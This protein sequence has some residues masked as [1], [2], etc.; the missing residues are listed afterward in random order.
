MKGIINS[1]RVAVIAVLLAV[2]AFVSAGICLGQSLPDCGGDAINEVT[3]RI[4]C[5]VGDAACWLSKGG[6][7]TDYI[8]IKTPR[9]QSGKPP[10]WEKIS[11]GS[12]EKGDVAVFLSLSHYAYVE[13]VTRDG[14]GRP[15][16]LDL[17]EYNYGGCWVDRSNMVTDKY[18]TVNKRYG[19]D[20]N[21]VDGGFLRP[22]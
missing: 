11:A 18:K 19:V 9:P 20:P 15:I 10:R 16:S 5:T 12:V 7:C 2:F 22:M 17:S 4:G 21:I 13:S 6:Y 3:K 1:R 8:E 14:G